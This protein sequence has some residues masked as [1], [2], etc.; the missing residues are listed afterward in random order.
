MK[1]N[2]IKRCSVVGCV[3]VLATVLTGCATSPADVQPQY[4]RLIEN[5]GRVEFVE[6]RISDQREQ[7]LARAA[8]SFGLSPQ[9]THI[10]TGLQGSRRAIT[11]EDC[12]YEL[13]S[14]ELAYAGT[15]IEK[16]TYRFVDER[17]FQMQ[18]AFK[19]EIG[20]APVHRIGE[21]V[22]DDL[23]LSRAVGESDSQRW[24][25]KSDVVEVLQDPVV[26]TMA[27]QISDAKLLERVIAQR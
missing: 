9:C 18:F 19:R 23:Q 3:M 22:S 7:V 11:V 15:P 10:K 6:N 21:S 1:I 17:L 25:G 4:A 13:Y 2:S 8:T 20:G 5:D 27:L 16:V 26:G 24:L 12:V 14:E